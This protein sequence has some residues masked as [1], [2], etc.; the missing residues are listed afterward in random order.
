VLQ[1][2]DFTE[3]LLHSVFKC[4]LGFPFVHFPVMLHL[5]LQTTVE[6]LHALLLSGTTG[7]SSSSAIVRQEFKVWE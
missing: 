3:V 4:L 1:V 6:C 2:F 5:T 7:S